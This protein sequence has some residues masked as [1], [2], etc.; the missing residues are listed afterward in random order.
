V[1]V[2]FGVGEHLADLEVDGSVIKMDLK[3]I[4]WICG[5]SLSVSVLYTD[6][7]FCECGK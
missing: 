2:N 4:E 1:L 6:A 3:E 5:F 7:V